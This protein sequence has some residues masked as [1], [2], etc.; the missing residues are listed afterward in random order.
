L[1]DLLA[2]G[3]TFLL[4]LLKMGRDSGQQL[5]D[6]RCRDIRHD[7]ES[8]DRHTSQGAAGEAVDPAQDAG[9]VVCRE[10]G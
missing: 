9:R 3:F 8:E 2:P 6:D 5:Y 10:A 1:I 4:E 7:I